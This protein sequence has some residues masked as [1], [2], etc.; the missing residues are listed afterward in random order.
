MQRMM[1]RARAKQDEH[2][3][4]LRNA[5]GKTIAYST[6]KALRPGKL[7][8]AVP[9]PHTSQACAACGHL[10]PHNWDS[11]A[12]LVC[13]RCGSTDNHDANAYRVIAQRG[14]RHSTTLGP[15]TWETPATRPC[16]ELRESS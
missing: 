11:Q 5:W 7:S 9:A 2:G 15:R 6:Y 10:H 3:R 4:V 13:Q 14:A 16:V 1:R 8:L 12:L